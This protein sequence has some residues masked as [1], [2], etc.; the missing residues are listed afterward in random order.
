MQEVERRTGGPVA[1]EAARLERARPQPGA[2]ALLALQ[3]TA[4]NRAVAL[5]V[6]RVDW[7]DKL[8]TFQPGDR[9][10]GGI[11]HYSDASAAVSGGAFKTTAQSF[12]DR[13]VPDSE[14][15]GTYKDLEA[16]AK[17]KDDEDFFAWF[18]KSK[19]WVKI[20]KKVPTRYEMRALKQVCKAGVLFVA[21]QGKKVHFILKGLLNDAAMRSMTVRGT[22]QHPNKRGLADQ[23]TSKEL[24]SVYRNWDSLKGSVIFYDENGDAMKEA[25][26]EAGPF[27]SLWDEYARGRPRMVGKYKVWE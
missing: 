21:G 19:Y 8:K 3:Q 7:K 14:S 27:K 24:R 25:P 23:T 13:V 18:K 26:W 6:Q 9:I 17:S 20:E 5:Q 10:Y 2:A 15:G 16:A 4:G 1:R 22:A 11:P 12:I